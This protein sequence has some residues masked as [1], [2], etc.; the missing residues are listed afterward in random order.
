M[1]EGMEGGTMAKGKDRADALWMVDPIPS[2]ELGN[3]E[4]ALPIANCSSQDRP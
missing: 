4:I 3:Q 1:E 2:G